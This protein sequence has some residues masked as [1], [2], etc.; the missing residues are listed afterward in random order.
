MVKKGH[1]VVA[2]G[3]IDTLTDDLVHHHMAV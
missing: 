1:V 2:S 3:P